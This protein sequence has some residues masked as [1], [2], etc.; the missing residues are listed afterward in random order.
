MSSIIEL[1]N[2]FPN[3]CRKTHFANITYLLHVA[4]LPAELAHGIAHDNFKNELHEKLLDMYDNRVYE[5]V[6]H[7]SP[8]TFNQY[9]TR[10]AFVDAC[11]MFNIIKN[12]RGR[13]RYLPPNFVRRPHA[14][15]LGYKSGPDIRMNLN[16]KKLHICDSG[17]NNRMTYIQ[18]NR[19]VVRNE[20]SVLN[21]I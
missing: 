6:W 10:L 19:L 15:R 1:M 16:G 8:L 2:N 11:A 7:H 21:V 13:V 3:F 9:A 18:A 4:G 14:R 12:P 5:V 17:S 20:T